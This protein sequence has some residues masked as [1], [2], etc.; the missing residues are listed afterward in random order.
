[1]PF[2]SPDFAA[3]YTEW[4]SSRLLT[5]V[6]EGVTE[7]STPLLDPLNDGMRVYVEPTE[8]GFLLHDGGLTMEMLSLHGIDI[9][10]SV[11]R[12]SLT[13]TV[14]RTCGLMIEDGRIQ[15][16]ADRSSL[17]QR[18]HF[19]L[20]GMHRISDLWLTVRTS[21]GTDFFERV[22]T[23]LDEKNV[24]Y[25]TNISIPGKTVQHPIDIVI[26]LPQRRERLIKL[27]GTPSVNTAKIVS[28]SW[29]EIQ[30]IRPKAERVVLVNDESQI[31]GHEIRRLS[32][33][34]E[35]ILR[36]YSTAVYRW[37]QRHKPEFE[38]FWR[39]A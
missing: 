27:I 3:Q 12:S 2:S 29:I 8:N 37:S 23:Y 22:C 33:Q 24:L 34:T 1:M 11:R 16:T 30:Q 35:A 14:L 9:Q 13:E 32:E 39:A 6:R 5:S 25:S 21:G 28:F 7:L 17:P 20:C 15:T 38:S 10:A 31:E 26:P 18:M 36:G 4:L 19:L